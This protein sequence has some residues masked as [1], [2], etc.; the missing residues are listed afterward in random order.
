MD[1]L[2]TAGCINTGDGMWFANP[3]A[4]GISAA[5]IAF[6]G[7]RQAFFPPSWKPMQG[8]GTDQAGAHAFATGGAQ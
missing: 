2:P 5:L 3:Y 1:G 4:P 7:N 8:Y 6:Q